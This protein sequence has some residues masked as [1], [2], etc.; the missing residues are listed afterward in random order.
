MELQE[1]AGRMFDLA[2]EGEA[3]QLAGY[4]DAGVD[5]NLTNQA[6]DTLLMLAAYHGHPETVAV[7]LARG[8]D[9]NRANDRH[10]TPLAAAVFKGENEIISTLAAAG[11]D[12]EGGSP[13]AIETAQMFRRADL[14]AIIR[15]AAGSRSDGA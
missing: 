4:L 12:P 7:L 14:I 2:R 5:V 15:R 1:F 8:A 13:T 9:P 10:Q 11:A 6:G 3:Q